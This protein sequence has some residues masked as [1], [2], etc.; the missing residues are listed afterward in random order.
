MDALET[1]M[2]RRSIRKYT[3]ESISDELL[4]KLLRAGMVAPSANNEQ[5]WHFI[6][7]RNR[8][9]YSEII[10][11]HPYSKMLLESSAALVVCADMELEY[12]KSSGYWIQDCSAATENI[13]LAAHALSLGACW[14]GI[15]PR[16]IRMLVL[17]FELDAQPLS[18]GLQARDDR[19]QDR[20]ADGIGRCYP[21]QPG[22]RCLRGG[23]GALD[24][25]GRVFHR[26]H[27]L[28]HPRPVRG[29]VVAAGRALEDGEAK[30]LLERRDP[31]QDGGVVDAQ[32]PG[33][34][35]Q[36]PLARNREDEA[37]IVP[38]HLLHFRTE[39]LPKLRI[40]P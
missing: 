40:A 35:R 3:D 27:R 34:P 13:L 4:E 36:R 38:I 11:V 20:V 22:Q 21:H 18:L 7:V 37:D 10:E 6:V 17:R 25:E 29:D 15:H 33:R 23:D 2:S 16:Q 8:D 24:P 32:A 14:I 12:K 9:V 28:Q 39:P 19:R 31:P 30:P 5:P 1:I 26:A